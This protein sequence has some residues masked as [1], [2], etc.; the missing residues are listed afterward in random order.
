MAAIRVDLTSTIDLCAHFD[1]QCADGYPAS[2]IADAFSTAILIRYSRA[3]ASGARRGLGD[4]ALDA[5][6]LGQRESHERFRAFRDKHIAD[7]VNAFE[8]TRVQARYCA[9]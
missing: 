5:P 2:E 6:S 3:L 4:E 1:T 9:E 8:A 7:S